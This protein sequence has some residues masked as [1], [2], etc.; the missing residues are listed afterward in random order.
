MSSIAS[1][2]KWYWV[3]KDNVANGFSS[4]DSS[5]ITDAL[6]NLMENGAAAKELFISTG[7]IDLE[8]MTFTPSA[9]NGPALCHRVFSKFTSESLHYL[10]PLGCSK[11]GIPTGEQPFFNDPGKVVFCGYKWLWWNNDHNGDPFVEYENTKIS[12]NSPHWRSYEEKDS[13]K[14]EEGYQRFMA[15]TANKQ[16]AC[17]TQ[18][19]SRFSANFWRSFHGKPIMIQYRNTD[20]NSCRPIARISFC[21]FWKSGDG[22]EDWTPYPLEISKILEEA[23]LRREYEV[24]INVVAEGVVVS[25]VVN[26]VEMIQYS[27]NSPFKR[28]EVKRIGTPMIESFKKRFSSSMIS[29]KDFIPPYWTRNQ[30]S[31]VYV[32]TLNCGSYEYKSIDKI[33]NNPFMCK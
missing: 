10:I 15:P 6:N 18:I 31:D 26:L 14:L 23:M 28:R 16:E 20:E 29:D 21:W 33:I 24:N 13:R 9:P 30:Q 3:G 19:N 4:S 22:P 5:R 11:A 1:D 2:E 27:P 25:K 32:E 17:K 12:E 7:R 8:Q